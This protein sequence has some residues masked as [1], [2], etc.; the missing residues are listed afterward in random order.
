MNGELEPVCIDLGT[1]LR[2]F[3]Q[4]YAEELLARVQ[5]RTPVVTGDL[6][7]GWGTTMHRESF[8]VWNTKEYADYVENGTPHMAPRR[9]LKSTIAEGEQIAEIA[10]AKVGLKK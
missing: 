4:A 8:D 7:A 5:R 1:R 10:A 3:K 2:K 9:M 6:Q